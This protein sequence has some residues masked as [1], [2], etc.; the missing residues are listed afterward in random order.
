VIEGV[1]CEW[2]PDEFITGACAR[3]GVFLC[4]K[5]QVL[6]GAKAYCAAC[7]A[8]PEV[9]W[10]EQLRAKW[11]GVKDGWCW[12]FL[13]LS[14]LE[15]VAFVA[16]T[17]DLVHELASGRWAPSVRL[18]E[19]VPALTLLATMTA[20]HASFLTGRK[21]I[22]WSIGVVPV[23]GGVVALVQDQVGVAV[24][25][26]LLFMFAATAWT[27]TR[28]K[29]F[30]RLHVPDAELQRYHA[31]NLDN[32]AAQWAGRI[33]ALGLFIP[34]A[35]LVAIVLGVVGLSQVN[36]AASPPVGK[37]WL[38]VFAIAVGLL[39]TAFFGAIFWDVLFH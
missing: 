33:A 19:R 12:M 21:W 20:L 25:W 34:F 32:P 23:V 10:L 22:R 37:R 7:A 16:F 24:F 6:V 9:S 13:G 3:C 26:V 1:R 28:N 35:G 18:P 30:F 2:H 36:P 31:R 38:G 29:L 39:E 27:D 11:L 14:V 4:A 5:E 15:L 17:G 8:R